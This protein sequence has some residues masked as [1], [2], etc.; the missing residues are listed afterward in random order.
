[1]NTKRLPQPPH[2]LQ[3]GCAEATIAR[4][5]F[6]GFRDVVAGQRRDDIQRGKLIQD[7]RGLWFL[8][9]RSHDVS[10]PPLELTTKKKASV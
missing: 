3:E 2:C 8:P 5:R 6:C 1:M 4:C 7:E 9:I 10:E